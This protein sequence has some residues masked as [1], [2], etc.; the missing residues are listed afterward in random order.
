MLEKLG[1][2]FLS[3]P[4]WC[5]GPWPGCSSRLKLPGGWEEA[6]KSRPLWEGLLAQLHPRKVPTNSFLV[7]PALQMI[8]ESSLGWYDGSV[9]ANRSQRVEMEF[10]LQLFTP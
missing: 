9:I 1:V 2:K 8:Q 3:G 4:L 6:D 5:A 7:C 10:T